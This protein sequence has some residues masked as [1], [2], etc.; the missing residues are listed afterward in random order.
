[1]VMDRINGLEW[2][3]N[4]IIS[5][6]PDLLR[7]LLQT[8]VE[9]LMGADVDGICGAGYGEIS[10][11][12]VNMRNGYRQRRWDTRVGSI[13]LAIPKLRR[14]SYFPAWLLEPRRRAE[15]ALM[16]VVT[17]AYVCGVSTRKMEGLVQALGLDSIS[18]AQVSELAKSLD[19][20]VSEFRERALTSGPYRYVWLDALTQ[21]C[22]E[23][24][25]VVNVSMVVATG[26]NA[27]GKR[28]ILG[29]DVFTG[30]DASSWTAFLRELKA[31]GLTGVELI[32]SDAHPG[33][34]GAIAA[35]FNGV[36]WQRCRTHYMCNL[37][38]RV[39]KSMQQFVATSVRTIFSQPDA[40][41]VLA[42]HKRVIEQL[43]VKFPQIADHLSQAGAEILSF[44]EFPKEHWRQIWSN[45]PQERLN[46]EIRRRTDVVGIFP[47]RDSILRLVGAVLAEQHEE[48][49]ISRRYM[50]SIREART[51]NAQTEI[52]EEFCLEQCG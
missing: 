42:Q 15:K 38:T 46:K 39:P 34:K 45:N 49:A 29:F 22:R 40:A 6:E 19:A 33:L 44:V 18:R 14:G 28:E 37:L 12:R 52:S 9:A 36:A 41:A 7:K 16:Q 17:E 30:E 24:S 20:E 47:N 21:R 23:G 27:A 13:N 5:A 2:L 3:R 1:M 8:V 10:P 11:D 50:T 43:S 26:V 35:T 48:W 4:K 32:I 25:R 51:L 31:R